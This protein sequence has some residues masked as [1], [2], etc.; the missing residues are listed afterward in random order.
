MVDGGCVI[1][2]VWGLWWLGGCWPPGV[3]AVP[4]PSG[5]ERGGTCVDVWDVQVCLV[6]T[7]HKTIVTNRDHKSDMTYTER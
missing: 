2:L 7:G 3:H 4:H 1:L 5:V 6:L